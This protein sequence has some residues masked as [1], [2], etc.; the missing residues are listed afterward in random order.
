MP[1][2]APPY[3]QMSRRTRLRIA[4]A[5]GRGAVDCLNYLRWWPG[6]SSADLPIKP[7]QI[8]GQRELEIYILRGPDL[9]WLLRDGHIDVGVASSLVF[10]EYDIDSL[11]SFET[12]P[13]GECRLS[14]LEPQ[15]S[16]EI[17]E[18]IAARYVSTA[19]RLLEKAGTRYT[20]MVKMTGCVESA[21]TLGIAGRVVDVVGTG[22]SARS[23][24]LR[25]S[26][27][28]ENY[29]HEIFIRSEDSVSSDVLR[30]LRSS[31]EAASGSRLEP[32]SI[33]NTS[34]QQLPFAKSGSETLS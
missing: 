3:S 26:I 5:K 25:E 24:G 28:L 19:A 7:W 20:R 12:L 23:H 30:E 8:L 9:P 11:S 6:S 13:L 22:E 18:I 34:T 10:A 21:V 1:P 16:G 33:V 32:G 27:I 14:L 4:I 29:Q 31:I 2:E 15:V 17:P